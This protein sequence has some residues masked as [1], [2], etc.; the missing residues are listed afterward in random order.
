MLRRRFFLH[1]DEDGREKLQADRDGSLARSVGGAL[2]KSK[3]GRQS[4]ADFPIF[5]SPPSGL[6]SFLLKWKL[7]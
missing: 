3:D 1:A 5:S 7:F 4:K 6:A 2:Y